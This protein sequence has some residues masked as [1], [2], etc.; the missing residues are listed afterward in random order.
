MVRLEDIHHPCNSRRWP[1][2]ID[3]GNR[4]RLC[5]HRRIVL[6]L[7]IEDLVP[8][9]FDCDRRRRYTAIRNEIGR[10]R[11]HGFRDLDQSI[12]QNYPP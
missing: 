1:P 9:P 12:R 5:R 2:T 3:Y 11:D 6:L 8:K 10:R 7:A 4:Y